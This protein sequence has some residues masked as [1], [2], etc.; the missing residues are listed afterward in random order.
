MLLARR[1]LPG[2]AP[3]WVAHYVT[4]CAICLSQRYTRGPPHNSVQ[5]YGCSS[6]NPYTFFHRL[7]LVVHACGAARYEY[8]APVNSLLVKVVETR[9]EKQRAL[10]G[11]CAVPCFDFLFLYRV[12]L[13]KNNFF[14]SFQKSS[15]RTAQ[16]E[17]LRRV[18]G[19][20]LAFQECACPALLKSGI[21]HVFRM[22]A[23][24]L[25]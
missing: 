2:A 14:Q 8:P 21:L 6:E 5:W 13:H 3:A 9:F 11:H 4:A 23:C 24:S 16:T 10:I 22:R 7:A 12:V 19:G 15:T 17:R 1:A 20:A 25:T 18:A